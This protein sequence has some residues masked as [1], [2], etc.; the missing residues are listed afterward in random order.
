MSGEALIKKIEALPPEQKAE[1]EVFVDLVTTRS[2]LRP[3][4]DRLLD[5]LRRIDERRERLARE[6]GPFDSVAA[7]RE[8][9]DE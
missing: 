7:I 3:A 4:G 1:V 5:L 2:R 9:R 8:L 6:V